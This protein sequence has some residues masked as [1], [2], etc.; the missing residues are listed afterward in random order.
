MAC[1]GVVRDTLVPEDVFIAGVQDEGVSAFAVEGQYVHLNGPKAPLLKVGAF[2]RVVRPEGKV[3]DP[4]NGDTRGIYYKDLGTIRVEAVG[5]KS[6]TARVISSCSGMIKGD[7]VVALAPKAAVEYHGDLSSAITAVP[8]SGLFGPI[9]LGKDDVM[10]LVAGNFCF[11]GL[12]VRDGIK[13]GDRFTVFRP[14]PPFDSKDMDIDGKRSNASYSPMRNSYW[15]RY[16]WNGMLRA[17]TLPPEV[18]GDIVVVEAGDRVSTAK[19]INSLSEIHPGDLV[20][21]R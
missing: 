20:V 21:K 15:Y 4:L 17:R 6:A 18:L 8:E 1:L 5:G 13:P 9:L 19:V 11:I 7:L 10:E 16:Q 14:Y 2:Q 12:G 3:H